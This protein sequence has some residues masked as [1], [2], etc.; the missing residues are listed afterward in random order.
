MSYEEKY[1][2]YKNKY[3]KLKELSGGGVSDNMCKFM[4]QQFMNQNDKLNIEYNL[5]I[6]ENTKKMN[7]IQNLILIIQE[8]TK[9][10]ENVDK[11]NDEL[12]NL[13]VEVNHTKKLTDYMKIQI[14]EN[15]K[16]I[17]EIE[18]KEKEIEEQKLKENKKPFWKIY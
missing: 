3:L 11:L 15:K 4:I 14:D 8:K 9:K 18:K 12:N 7:I 2:K 6:K 10:N 16:T 5:N 17:I 1:I 13:V